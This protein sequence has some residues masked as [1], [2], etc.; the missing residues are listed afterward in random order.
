MSRHSANADPRLD[1]IINNPTMGNMTRLVV[2][3]ILSVGVVSA[4][5]IV[6]TRGGDLGAMKDAVSVFAP[7][8]LSALTG[9]AIA[10]TAD[11][12]T[13]KYIKNNTVAGEVTTSDMNTIAQYSLPVNHP[14]IAG[15]FENNRVD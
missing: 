13:A 15:N 9:G 6:L 2:A 11:S 3:G 4:A 10:T 7:F 1:D 8:I 5:L 12:E 14:D